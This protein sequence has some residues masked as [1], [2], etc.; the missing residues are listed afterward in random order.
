M[1]LL[2]L[3]FSAVVVVVRAFS[4][5]EHAIIGDQAFFE[6]SNKAKTEL[7]KPGLQYAAMEGLLFPPLDA[8][9]L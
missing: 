8:F 1:K 9:R 4:S 6:A 2:L 5:G 7:R 3:V